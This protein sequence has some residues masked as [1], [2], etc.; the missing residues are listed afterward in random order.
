MTRV[1]ICGVMSEEEIELCAAAGAAAL[2]F[3][4]EYPLEVPWNLERRAA[5]ALMRHVPPFVSRVIVVGGDPRTVSDLT[6]QL[7]PHA[8]QLHGSEPLTVTAELVTRIHAL[9]A[10]VIKALRFSVE[11]GSCSLPGLD[12]LAAAA[13]I[14]ETGVDALVLDSVSSIRPAGTGKSIDWSVARAIRDAVRV[15][16]ILAGGL[17]VG[18][19]RQAVAGVLPYAVDVISGVEDASGRKDPAKVREFVA[20]ATGSGT[21]APT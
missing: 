14:V 7:R 15:P 3:V 21:S 16:V 10:T 6:E 8:V 9:G 20:V 17:N 5:E 4:V 2:G 11:T 12:P 13:R 19:V 18:N 1:K